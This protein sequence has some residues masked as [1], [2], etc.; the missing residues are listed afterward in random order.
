MCEDF[1]N[2]HHVYHRTD[3]KLF[4]FTISGIGAHSLVSFTSYSLLVFHV[5]SKSMYLCNGRV[6]F[7]F[8]DFRAVDFAGYSKPYVAEVWFRNVKERWQSNTHG[9]TKFVQKPMIRSDV[10]GTSLIKFE[11]FPLY[12]RAPKEEHGIWSAPYFDCDGYVNDWILTYSV[13]FFGLNQRST[14]VEFQ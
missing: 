1:P 6:D 11:R 13:P 2:H 7:D 3:D 10:K 5:T 4:K 14:D 8:V 12:F 9:L